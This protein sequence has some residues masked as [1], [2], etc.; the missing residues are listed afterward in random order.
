MRSGRNAQLWTLSPEPG[1][2][3]AYVSNKIV[4]ILHVKYKMSLQG[5]NSMSIHFT[6]LHFKMN[7]T[8]IKKGCI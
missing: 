7:K 3:K 2:A 6:M 1:I 5:T 4:K 8:C